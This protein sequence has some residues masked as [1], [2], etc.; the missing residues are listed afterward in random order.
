MN[1]MNIKEFISQ[2]RWIRDKDIKPL[3]TE[4]YL[5]KIISYISSQE[6]WKNMILIWGSAL[7]LLH[8][9]ARQSEDLD[10][11]VTWMDYDYFVWICEDIAYFL[12]SEWHQTSIE[13]SK[14]NNWHCDFEIDTIIDTKD[15]GPINLPT[16]I[17]LEIKIDAANRNWNYNTEYRQLINKFS[18]VLIQTAP[19][20]IIVSKKIISFIERSHQNK[21]HKDIYDIAAFMPYYGFDREYLYNELEIYY[22]NQIIEILNSKLNKLVL[23]DLD[24]LSNRVEKILYSNEFLENMYDI[25]NILINWLNQR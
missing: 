7:R 24:L 22:D 15:F 14:A 21:V 8:W 1:S 17:E 25:K 11:D 20:E 9:S 18:N 12:N 4:Y 5:S 23:C 6:F 19:I 16:R 3:V 2:Y 10:Y 13:T